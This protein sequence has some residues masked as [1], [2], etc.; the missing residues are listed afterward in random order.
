MN[1][2]AVTPILVVKN[3]YLTAN[4]RPGSLWVALASIALLAGASILYWQDAFHWAA[5]LEAT[6]ESTFQRGQYWSLVTSF[7]IHAD[8]RHLFSNGLVFGLLCYLIYGYFGSLSYPTISFVLGAVVHAAALSTYPPHTRLL[9]ASGVVYLMAAFWLT[10]FVLIERRL[11]P[12]KRLMRAVGFGV[13]VLVPSSIEAGV[14]YRSHGIGFMVGV[15]WGIV[16]FF[17]MKDLIRAK[18]EVVVE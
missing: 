12:M 1:F 13:L 4:P 8:L 17:V 14:S 7:L 5:R 16:Q 18:E 2:Q 11:S 15:V 9:G 3:T 6:P 10:M